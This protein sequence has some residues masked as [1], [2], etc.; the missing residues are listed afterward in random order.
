MPSQVSDGI[1]ASR[2]PMRAYSGTQDMV[3]VALFVR[4]EAKPGKEAEVEAFLKGGLAIVEGEPATFVRFGI[5]VAPSTFGKFD[6]CPGEAARAGWHQ[7]GGACALNAS[8]T[9]VVADSAMSAQY[10]V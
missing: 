4:L 5:R 1:T 9:S 3:N 10:I 7:G 8:E 2:R 6:D